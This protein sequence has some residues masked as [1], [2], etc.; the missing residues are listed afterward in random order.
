[1]KTFQ[2][3]LAFC[4]TL[5][6][7]AQQGINYKALIKDN[8]GNVV[9]SQSVTV[10]LSVLEGAAM[11]TSY[12]ESHN[13]ITDAN[14]L[15]VLDIGQGTPISGTF[16][17][18]NWGADDHFLNVQVDIGGGLVDMGTTQFMAV[19]YALSS[20]DHRWENVG[21]HIYNDTQSVNIGSNLAPQGQLEIQSNSTV[22][23]SQLTLTETEDDY[24]RLN[25]RTANGDFYWTVA[26]LTQ[27]LVEDDR[28]NIYNS[29]YGNI[30]MMKGDGRVGVG[31]DPRTPFHVQGDK[32][33]LFGH[34]T[35]NG[36]QKL[37]F[38]PDKLGAFRAGRVSNIQWNGANIGRASAAF[39]NSTEATADYSFAAG[40]LT[41]ASGFASF[42]IG[43]GTEA[44]GSKSAAFGEDTDASGSSSSAFGYFSNASGSFSMASGH[45]ARALAYSSMA[46]GRYNTGLGDSFTWVDTDPL[47]EIGNGADNSN[48]S[49]ALTVLKNGTITA[50]SFD[51]GEIT[52]PKALTTK[53]YVDLNSGGAFSTNSNITSNANGT[54]STDNFVFGSPQLDDTGNPDNDI[55]MFFNKTK[56]AFRAGNVNDTQWDDVNVG[57][58]SFAGGTNTIASG[59]VS[60]AMGIDTEASGNNSTALN[61]STIASGTN[62]FAI[63]INTNAT[64]LAS[65]ASGNDTT[66]SGIYSSTFGLGN[67]AIG[68][69][70]SAFGI[71]SQAVGGLSFATGQLTVAN[72]FFSS[73]FGIQTLSD[74]HAS[75]VLGRFNEGGGNP[76]TWV[77][78]DPLFEIGNGSS[79][80]SRTNAL[81]V[82]KNGT[83]L[84]PTFD[85]AEIT[86][87]KALTTKEYVDGIIPAAASGLEAIDEGNGYGWRLIG[88]NPVHY[89]NIGIRAVDLS[90]GLGAGNLF[91]ALGSYSFASG[92]RVIALGGSSAAFNFLTE[93]SGLF[94]SAFGEG[95]NAES[96][97]SFTLGR[98]NIGGGF[99]GIWSSTDPVFEIGIGTSGSPNNAI[100]VLKDGK[101]GIGT[102]TPRSILEVSHTNGV[103]TTSDY[104]NAFTIANESSNDSWQFFTQ[105]DGY[106]LLYKDGNYRGSFNAASGVYG[107]VSDKNLKKNIQP[108]GEEESDLLMNLNPVKYKMKDQKD[109]RENYG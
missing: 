74:S 85:L 29:R 41:D 33:V 12:S 17:G 38:L 54:Y 101:T 45:G 98:Y 18:I 42:A 25:Y 55:R 36:G 60:F 22:A 51:L 69:Y 6:S 92:D 28:F 97:A 76:S 62:S 104:T 100:T 2:I 94:S 40:S 49:N 107:P 89:G 46:F 4:F 95:T 30:M 75:F 21:S 48:R 14:G 64:G 1:M 70:S 3:I 67:Q 93:A 96:Y 5:V 39:G 66:A 58:R 50:P 34:D 7:F 23:N 43:D 72:G 88:N 80:V 105:N 108:L 57:F 16:A 37:M 102:H 82:L 109:G 71:N 79:D 61:N 13:P 56:G 31:T 44:S 32:R 63:G 15:V 24:A 9:D 20:S 91:G 103:P 65:F 106:L 86:D 59:G 81:T 84:A 90:N 8:L 35:I 78:T 87:P 83:V 73:V 19:P 27:P 11:S 47:F 52:D 99:P 68:D 26:G 53:E 10:Q 77:A